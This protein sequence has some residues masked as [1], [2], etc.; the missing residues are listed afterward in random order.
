MPEFGDTLSILASG[1]RA[2]GQR[3]RH[4][5]EN[6]SN[7]DT[8]GYR[9]KTV[10]F[11]AML[12]GG[13]ETGEIRVGR[14]MLDRTDLRRVHDPS[15]PMSDEDGYFDASNVNLITEIADARE[16]QRSYEA[17]LKMFEQTRRM[18]GALMDILKR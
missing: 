9:R 4:V 17:N 14:V 6:I 2:Q 8:P 10:A 12:E 3:L 16:A 15:H 7:A 5:S 18:S 1:L 13:R 11:S